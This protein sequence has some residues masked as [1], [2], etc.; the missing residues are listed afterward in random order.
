MKNCLV[1][2]AGKGKGYCVLL[3]Q[4]DSLLEIFQKLASSIIAGAKE[5]RKWD[6][7]KIKEESGELK[8]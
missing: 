8:G 5:L 2:K 4:A 6:N 1:R 7:F 3:L